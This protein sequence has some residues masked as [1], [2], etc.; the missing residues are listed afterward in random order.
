MKRLTFAGRILD[1]DKGSTAQPY[2]CL[3]RNKPI[4]VNETSSHVSGDRIASL[5]RNYSARKQK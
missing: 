1:R 5:F 3:L 4:I 2:M